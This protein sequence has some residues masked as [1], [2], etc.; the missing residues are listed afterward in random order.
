MP[1]DMPMPTTPLPWRDVDLAPVARKLCRYAEVWTTSDPASDSTP[2]TER[3]FDLARVLVD[4]LARW[5]VEAEVDDRCYVYATVPSPLPPEQAAALPTVALVAH[6]DTS[7]DA[8]GENVCPHVWPD[9]DGGPLRFP[10][11]PD[12][13][14]DPDRQPALADH[15]GH[16][17]ITSDGTTL[18]GSDDK[19]GVALIMQLAEELT[20]ADE[21]AVARGERPAARPTL[22]L[23]FTPDEEIGRGADHVDYARL[24]A[25]VAYTL[26]GGGTDVLNVETFNAA[27]GVLTVEGV[28]VHPGYAK[29]VMVN[30][31]RVATRF[32][33]AL[34][35]DPAPETT[36][37]REGYLH[38]HTV[39]ATT[40][41]ATVR[42]LIRAFDDEGMESRRERLRALAADLAD[43]FPEA[44]VSLEIAES[45]RNMRSYIEAVN[46]GA[47]SVAHAAAEAVGMELTTEPVRGGTD[48]ARMSE[49]GLPTPNVFTGGYDFHSRFEWNSVQNL[50]RA[51]RYTHALVRQ[52][53]RADP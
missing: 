31:A 33:E 26:D 29:G 40:E 53:A 42:V 43:A 11:D 51:L 6:L 5:G 32:V 18:L 25:D 28:G 12:L 41:L 24:G 17:L 13:V 44:E 47:I 52:W 50:E 48:G 35:D 8:L 23:L 30:A 14:L 7:P 4:D 36:A 16:D 45:Y 20:R 21:D 15:V 9:Y 37:G 22:R 10:G 34:A 46:E 2:S 1:P 39:E 27:E 19:A 49:R 38:P 3:Q